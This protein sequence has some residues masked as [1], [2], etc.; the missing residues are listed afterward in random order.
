MGD[1]VIMREEGDGKPVVEA[2]NQNALSMSENV[3]RLWLDRCERVMKVYNR[4]MG[5]R[6]STVGDKGCEGDWVRSVWCNSLDICAWMTD[7][8]CCIPVGVLRLIHTN[9]HIDTHTLLWELWCCPCLGARNLVLMRLNEVGAC[10]WR[11]QGLWS[12]QAAGYN[13]GLSKCQPL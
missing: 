12:N 1:E 3:K 4:A 7:K 9:S 11:G 6:G 10:L 8:T 2:M 13:I 5:G